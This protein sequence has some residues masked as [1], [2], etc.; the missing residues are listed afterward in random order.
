MLCVCVSACVVNLDRCLHV[1]PSDQKLW[2]HPTI[3]TASERTMRARGGRDQKDVGEGRGNEEI[4]EGC[5]EE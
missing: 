3:L 2:G 1:K 5:G 4:E